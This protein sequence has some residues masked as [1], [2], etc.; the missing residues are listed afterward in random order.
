MRRQKNAAVLV[1]VVV[2]LAVSPAVFAGPDLPMPNG[3]D[4]DFTGNQSWGIWRESYWSFAPFPS[5]DIYDYTF[6]YNVY[7][8]TADIDT[9]VFFVA[10]ISL[11]RSG[12]DGANGANS[13]LLDTTAGNNGKTG[14]YG[15]WFGLVLPPPLF[16][17]KLLGPEVNFDG[18]DYEIMTSGWFAPGIGVESIGGNGGNGG[19]DEAWVDAIGG[20]GGS[21]GNGAAVIVTSNGGIHTTGPFSPGI[22][23]LSQG[24]DG[25]NGGSA[26]S[27]GY[28]KG[29][30]GGQGGSGGDVTVHNDGSVETAGYF[31]DGIVGLSLGGA[32]GDGG[33][34]GGAWGSG[35]GALG[36]SPGGTVRI[37]NTGNI[38]TSGTEA[39]GIFAQ[40]VGGFAGS[41]GSADGV[42]GWGGSGNS[43]GDGGAVT[44]TNSGTITTTGDVSQRTSAG[45]FAQS[46]G[47]GGGDAGGSAGVVVLG[48]TGS[49]GGNGGTVKVTNSGLLQTAADDSFGIVAQ[50]VGGGGGSGGG[51]GALVAIGGSGNSTGNGGTVTVENSGVITTA[52]DRSDSIFAQSIGGGGGVAG[53][54]GGA[55]YSPLVS[56]GGEGGAG[57]SGAAVTVNNSGDLETSGD[58]SRGVFAQSVGG[59]GG[60][61][62]A[63]YDVG[64]DFA[65]AMG[66]QSTGGGDGGQ[67][68]VDSTE[69]SILTAGV[70]SHGIHGQSVGGGGGSGGNA[71]TLA[72]GV[73]LSET[74]AFGGWAGAGGNGAAV[75]ITSGS[76]ITT[77]GPQAHGLYAESLGGG[78]GSGGN[79][80]NLAATVGGV[81]ELPPGVGIGLSL[82]GFG[83]DGG[84]G[85]AATVTSTGNLSTSGSRSYGAFAQS[86]GGGGGDGGN[87]VAGGLTFGSMVATMAIG[88]SGGSGGAGN[89]AFVDSAG[90]IDTQGDSAYGILAQSVGGGGG[91]GGNSIVLTISLPDL[92]KLVDE[93]I[94][95]STN[96]S[97]AVGGQGGSGGTGGAAEVTNHGPIA[98][99]GALA[100][101]ILAQS[102]GGGGGAGGDDISLGFS[103]IPNPAELLEVARS[104]ALDGGVK[105]GSSGG[106]GGSGGITTVHNSGAITTHE[107]FATGILAQSV[108]GGG[109]VSGLSI[110]DKYGLI[111]NEMPSLKLERRSSGNG[112][113]AVVT[114]DN[115][116]D[117]VT[118][119]GFAHGI[120]AQSIGGGGGFAGIK[121]DVG[122]STLDDSLVA[123]G[124]SVDG[125][126]G[127]GVGFAGSAGG[128]GSAGAVS[129]T[130]TG[131]I[132]TYGEMSHGIL[133]QSAAGSGW[134]G[135]VTVTLASDITAN[136]VDSDGIHA[137]SV[138]RYG[139]GDISINI[140]GGTVQGGSGAGAG[141]NID[142]GTNNTLTNAGTISALSG[143]AIL[144]SGGHD[145]VHND[146]L[147]IGKIDLG[148]GINAFNNHVAGVFNMGAVVGLGAGN[149]LTNAGILSP[150]GLGNIMTATLLGDLIQ[151]ASGVLEMEIGGFT[152]GSFDALYIEGTLTG[153]VSPLGLSSPMGSINFSLLPGYDIASE[154]GPGQSLT[155][156]F[157]SADG[158]DGFASGMSYSVPG[159][160]W[161]FQY[162][163]LQLDAGLFLRAVNTVPAPGALLLGTIGLALLGWRRRRM[164]W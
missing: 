91:A 148:T 112:S 47:G 18:G 32:G 66:G 142:G 35:G 29:G 105:L 84:D 110:K 151:S 71:Y 9:S 16:V 104:F 127:F 4:F 128:W 8:L 49:A 119:G 25:G 10:G 14:E 33:Y 132:T 62:G 144:G 88:G 50:S 42:V 78:G 23:A 135:P 117:I 155:L 37:E 115:S 98:T 57:G 31:A 136:G 126:L 41:A 27:G 52:G 125:S 44:V 113:G 22:Y 34:G 15:G 85:Q 86:V 147:V 55:S 3:D 17:V 38:L 80:I 11:A 107:D 83:G 116:A 65:F 70:S 152:P 95:P 99:E 130:H 51:S 121:D 129:V 108:G 93:A 60:A 149:D 45:I 79:A 28:A 140:G 72:V 103:V 145:T 20:H 73:G 68:D 154:I 123:A 1:S 21:G 54:H 146:G 106:S 69:A 89:K 63:A 122:A 2:L 163:V 120:L 36:S 143:T 77:Q 67:V 75:D 139:R 74:V 96:I 87:S 134:G 150:G 159:G 61:G 19:W 92:T 153:A 30:N 118:H 53:S 56:M 157:L 40:S 114:V 5:S 7:N 131:S 13:D 162:E 82:G 133:A 76:T 164:R 124:V 101:G 48:G 26:E 161:G 6:T 102:I 97:S 109:G 43:A 138:G 12:A 58:N 158:L 64:L 94:T 111:Q 100:H 39:R 24:G 46:I 59:G 90:S 137:Q 160:P 141:V 81:G 156:Q